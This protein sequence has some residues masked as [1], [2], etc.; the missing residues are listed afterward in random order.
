MDLKEKMRAELK[1]A[2]D[3]ASKAE[4]ENRDLTPDEIE[5]ASTHLKAYESAKADMQKV[6]ESDD[7]KS[8]LKDIGLDLGLESNDD[9]NSA[10]S[11]VTPSRGK[12]LGQLFIESAQYVGFMKAHG[13]R[14]PGDRARV[15]SEPM[16]LKGIFPK[17]KS[18][19]T[20][21]SDTSGGA[22][23]NPDVTGIYEALGRPTLT[24]RD[25]ISVRQ[26]DS[27]TVEFV[28][29]TSQPTA[30]APTPEAT[31]ADAPTHDTT[32]GEPILAAGGGYKPEG[33][34]AFKKVT[35]PVRTIA[36]WIPA[37][38]R[39]I[40][41]AS[42]LRGL[43]DDELLAD[44]AQ[45]EEDQVLNG[46]GTGEN[47]TGIRNTTGIQSQA[48][49]NT[50]TDL[51]PLLETTLKARTKVRTVGRAMPTAYLLNPVDW[52]KI[53]LARL[54]KNPQNEALAAGVPTLHGLPVVESE[55]I[56]PGV[57]LTGDFRK[58]VLWDRE[59]AS[60]SV[61]DSH[62]DF[63]IRNLV[64]ILAEERAAF[65]VRR[66]AAFVEIDLTAA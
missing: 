27:D 1:A 11:F 52:E 2:R 57:G 39:G 3:I 61:T 63:F 33:S 35:A 30:A 21:A 15:Q 26:T 48:Y 58:A 50:V 24:I 43:I 4:A 38:K 51:D 53:Q 47:L 65:G 60:I 13:N 64:A 41:D 46:D 29:Q 6:K 56:A 18:L 49:S 19:V 34:I 36:E 45:T 5:Q 25:L 20:G 37:T 54:A 59:Q 9:P 32:T 28:Q 12:S 62:S 55:N 40:A 44:L 16:G 7:V 14:A 10:S 31:T 8:A 66:P 23:V 42:Q 17:R 22:F